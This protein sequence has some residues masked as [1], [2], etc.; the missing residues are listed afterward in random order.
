MSLKKIKGLSFLGSF[1]ALHVLK[2]IFRIN[3]RGKK[4]FIQDYAADRIF[5]VAEKQRLKMLGYSQCTN[6]RICDTV[7]PLI[8]AKPNK[9]APSYLVGTFA[10]SLT[11]YDLFD[12]DFICGDCCECEKVCPQNVPIRGV[13]EF[14]KNGKKQIES[15]RA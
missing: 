1:F 13:I 6:C 12:D 3:Q 5:S 2:K 7:C 11:D 9:P 4:D 10:R 14:I 8:V 15:V